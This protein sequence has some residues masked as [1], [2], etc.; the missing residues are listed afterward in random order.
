MPCKDTCM[1]NK[2]RSN[3][4]PA[5]T[6][7]LWTHV[8]VFLEYPSSIRVIDHLHPLREKHVLGAR[9][10]LLACLACRHRR[11]YSAACPRES[12]TPLGTCS[13]AVFLLCRRFATLR[14]LQ[15]CSL[16]SRT[17]LGEAQ[18]RRRT[19]RAIARSKAFVLCHFVRGQQATALHYGLH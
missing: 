8:G 11:F 19:L 16:R 1:T 4:P 6:S 14:V 7:A 5:S 12:H 10:T 2:E 13:C 3:N 17:A 9:P 18:A 15:T